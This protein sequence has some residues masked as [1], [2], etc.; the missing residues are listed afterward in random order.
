M[1]IRAGERAS[2]R[3][4]SGKSR[5]TA[6]RAAYHGRQGR[7]VAV[8]CGSPESA[9]RMREAIRDETGG[10]WPIGTRVIDVT[11]R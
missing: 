5:F 7:R 11:Q 4:D 6:M 1:D 8:L 9:A 2:M 3:C 10:A